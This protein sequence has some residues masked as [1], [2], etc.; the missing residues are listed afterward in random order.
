MFQEY[1]FFEDSLSQWRHTEFCF[2]GAKHT[3]CPILGANLG[4][5]LIEIK[6]IGGG[7]K[8]HSPPWGDA[9]EAYI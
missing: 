8:P 6:N 7:L 4:F 9:T 2:G 3:F 1:F 5:L